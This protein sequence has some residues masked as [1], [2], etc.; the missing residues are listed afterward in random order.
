MPCLQTKSEQSL[1]RVDT[2]GAAVAVVARAVRGTSDGTSSAH[3]T[4]R[5]IACHVMQQLLVVVVERVYNVAEGR[6]LLWIFEPTLLHQLFE[7]GVAVLSDL[8][9]LSLQ[10]AW[11]DLDGLHAIVRIFAIVLKVTVS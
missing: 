3:R 4:R 6:S 8:W 1:S 7:R 9:P 11:Y 10:H 5:G 2:A